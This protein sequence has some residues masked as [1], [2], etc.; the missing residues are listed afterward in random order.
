MTQTIKTDVVI[1]GAGPVGLFAVFELGLLDIRAHVVDILDR[2]GGQCAELYPEKPIYDIPG[3]PVVTGQQLTDN[4]LE[5]IKPFGAEYHFSEIIAGLEKTEDD[6]FLLITDAGTRF[7]AKVVV[8]AAGGGSF[9][10]KKPPIDGVEAFEE[11]SVHYA[12]RKMDVFRGKRV[13]IVGGG[14]SALDWTLNLA[15]IAQRVTLMHRRDAFRAA[16]DSVN[17][18]RKLVEDGVVDLALGQVTELIGEDGVLR[19]VKAKLIDGSTHQ[20]ATDAMLPFFGLTM[21]LG[22]I[23]EW[24]L[25]LEEN[26]IPVDT[27]KFETTTPGIFAIG[28]INAYPG[29]LKL[30]LSGFHEA[31][32][33]A[34][35]AARRINPDRKVVFQYTTSSTSLQK[36]LG[37]A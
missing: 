18:M 29:K 20:I 30:I 31:A 9:Q 14:D 33:M 37:V 27:E 8:I 3:L 5:Q 36:K 13:L 7:D 28:D 17:K 35:A 21:K 19:A 16:P 6:R 23:A 4:L 10:P 32:L 24:G 2:P 22:P 25:N 1:I 26:L 11:K 34:Q 15:P 12:V